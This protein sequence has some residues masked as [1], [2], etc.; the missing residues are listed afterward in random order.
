MSQISDYFDALEVMAE[1]EEIS[2][3]GEFLRAVDSDWQVFWGGF[4]DYEGAVEYLM[5]KAGNL[6]ILNEDEL[7]DGRQALA[8]LRLCYAS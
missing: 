5:H 7:E 2:F 4:K 3:F 8:R 6:I 1:P